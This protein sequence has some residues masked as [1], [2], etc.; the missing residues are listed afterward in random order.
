MAFP[1]AYLIPFWESLPD[2]ITDITDEHQFIEVINLLW[3]CDEKLFVLKHNLIYFNGPNGLVLKFMQLDKIQEIYFIYKRGMQNSEDYELKNATYVRFGRYLMFGGE[4]TLITL[5]GRQCVQLHEQDDLIF[6]QPN[7]L[8]SFVGQ[9]GGKYYYMPYN[10]VAPLKIYTPV[11]SVFKFTKATNCEFLDNII[12][13]WSPSNFRIITDLYDS[14]KSLICAKT[15]D[16]INAETGEHTKTLPL[17]QLTECCM[18]YINSRQIVGRT[19][20]PFGHIEILYDE[21]RG[22][23]YVYNFVKSSKI[24]QLASYEASNVSLV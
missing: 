22:N 2:N 24:H 6:Y 11:R 20:Y 1:T 5:P 12:H 13:M 9:I 15:F 23:Y 21:N 4:F 16:L 3:K 8:T 14:E 18:D 17:I 19:L 10:N 7:T